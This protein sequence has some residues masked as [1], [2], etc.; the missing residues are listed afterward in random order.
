M[1]FTHCSKLE[2]DGFDPTTTAL[3]WVVKG[4]NSD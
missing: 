4:G 2:F 1:A 3:R